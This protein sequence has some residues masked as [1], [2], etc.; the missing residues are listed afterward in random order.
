MI[1]LVPVDLN[2]GPYC[3][4][5]CAY[6]GFELDSEGGGY[7]VTEH[8]GYY[9]CSKECAEDWIDDWEAGNE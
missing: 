6:T 5:Y 8:P 9:F 2:E 3:C 1:Q 7:I 4:E